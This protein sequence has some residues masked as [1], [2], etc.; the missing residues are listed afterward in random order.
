MAVGL[1]ALRAGFPSA[2]KKSLREMFPA[3]DSPAL[4]AR[5]ARQFADLP[6]ADRT[7]DWRNWKMI[8]WMAENDSMPQALLL[9]FKSSKTLRCQFRSA[10]C[11]HS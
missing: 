10:S 9:P 2:F 8:H 3:Q 5:I 1:C 11:H 6:L 4:L 7:C